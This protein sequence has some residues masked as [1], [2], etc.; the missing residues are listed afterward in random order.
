[1]KLVETGDTTP[2]LPVIVR[3]LDATE[4]AIEPLSS[5]AEHT[6]SSNSA[7]RRMPTAFRHGEQ[8][9]WAGK[10]PA[11]GIYGLQSV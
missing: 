4:H 7:E 2:G 11:S 1:M 5:A 6:N 3:W 9:E 8:G 10:V